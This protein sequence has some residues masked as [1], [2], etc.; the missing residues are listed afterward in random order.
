L[1]LVSAF[2]KYLSNSNT[3]LANK[4]EIKDS[5]NETKIFISEVID[6]NNEV[7]K[8]ET[9]SIRIDNIEESELSPCELKT[10]NKD[11]FAYKVTFS[12]EDPRI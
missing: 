4:N 11:D 6:A 9:E 2:I 7:Q 10:P 3:K 12:K 1:L 8:S 5:K